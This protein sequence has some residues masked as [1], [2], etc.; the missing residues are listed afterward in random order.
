MRTA[1][2]KFW[3]FLIALF[4]GL[5]LTALGAASPA[6]ADAGITLDKKAPGS[7]LLGDT[8]P[9]HAD[10]E[11][12]GRYDSLYNVEL[13]RRPA[14]RLRVRRADRPGIG[15][16][17]DHQH[18]PG[19][20]DPARVEQRHR[21]A[22][23]LIVHPEV[24]GQAQSADSDDDRPVDTNT[25]YVAGSTN[26]R[27]VPKFNQ[28]GT[29][30][31]DPEVVSNSDTTHTKRA[32]FVV[33]KSNTNSPEGE[34]LRGVHDQRSTYTLTIRNNKRVA[35]NNVTLTDYLPAQLEFLGC[36]DED[37]SAGGPRSTRVRARSAFRLTNPHPLPAPRQR[38]DRGQPARA[39]QASGN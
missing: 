34:L 3:T 9:L 13:L 37:N 33:E 21:P 11:Q 12:P 2:S 28:H 5:G 18:H 35:T 17:A 31:A 7:V 32:P 8:G 27:K 1:P 15:G 30:V 29:P 22:G 20:P 36:G 26:E 6:A 4:V 25:A 19:R 24:P 16:R 10:G 14:G 23:R 39:S 38:R